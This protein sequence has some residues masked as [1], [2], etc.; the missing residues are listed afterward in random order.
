MLPH[1]LKSMVKFGC[2]WCKKWSIIFR[3]SICAFQRGKKFQIAYFHVLYIISFFSKLIGCCWAWHYFTK[4]IFCNSMENQ[5]AL[6][7]LRAGYTS[8]YASALL[9]LVWLALRQ[10]IR[11]CS[12]SQ[13]AKAQYAFVRINN[14][15]DTKCGVKKSN[16]GDFFLLVYAVNLS[17]YDILH[18]F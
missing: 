4:R 13:V 2:S 7:S 11:T 1:R 5:K 17:A 10:E 9:A 6:P 16:I 18:I 3:F 14:S 8:K 15:W 12:N